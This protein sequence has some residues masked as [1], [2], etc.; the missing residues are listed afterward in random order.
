MSSYICMLKHICQSPTLRPQ[1]AKIYFL[2]EKKNEKKIFKK[3][4]IGLFSRIFFRV[5]NEEIMGFVFFIEWPVGVV[6]GWYIA[7]NVRN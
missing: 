7:Q 3:I 5:Q 2:K 6:A 4:Q 1:S